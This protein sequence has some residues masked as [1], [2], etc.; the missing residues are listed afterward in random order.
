MKINVINSNIILVYY[1]NIYYIYHIFSAIC[2]FSKHEKEIKWWSHLLLNQYTTK[3]NNS[4]NVQFDGSIRDSKLVAN[5]FHA[6]LKQVRN[7]VRN[8][9]LRDCHRSQ[10]IGIP[11]VSD[12][13]ASCRKVVEFDTSL[14]CETQYGN[15]ND[16]NRVSLQTERRC[17]CCR[18][19]R[20]KFRCLPADEKTS[21]N[22]LVKL[23]ELSRAWRCFPA[24]IANFS[25]TSSRYSSSAK[26]YGIV[27]RRACLSHFRSKIFS[28]PGIL[29]MRIARKFRVCPIQESESISSLSSFL[30]FLSLPRPPRSLYSEI[31]PAINHAALLIVLKSCHVCVVLLFHVEESRT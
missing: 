19:F 18:I 28:H 5:S 4:W 10:Y 29:R 24:S 7:R 2:S 6:R 17:C 31:H 16:D 12:C 20:L 30:P 1:S 14:L 23:T 11:K 13:A 21:G 8:E 22:V 9:D 27:A 3:T 25:S 26:I 15:E